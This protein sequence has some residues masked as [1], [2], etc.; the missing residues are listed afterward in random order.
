MKTA[1]ISDAEKYQK[2]L[3]R[4]DV[5]WSRVDKSDPSGCWPWTRLIDIWGYGFISIKPVQIKSHRAA[6]IL[7]H[8]MITSEQHVL[9]RCD[10]RPCCNPAHL[11]LATMT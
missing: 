10:N 6:W 9:H 11:F 3:K 1:R 4:S 8:G 2:I 5:F 7:T